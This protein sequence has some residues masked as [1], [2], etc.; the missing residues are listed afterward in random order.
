M[1]VTCKLWNTHLV[2]ISDC[3]K[4]NTT[5]AIKAHWKNFCFIQK[6]CSSCFHNFCYPL[7]KSCPYSHLQSNLTNFVNDEEKKKMEIYY[8]LNQLYL[9]KQQFYWTELWRFSLVA[10]TF[11]NS[12]ETIL[13]LQNFATPRK[14]YL[15]LIWNNEPEWLLFNSLALVRGRYTCMTNWEKGQ[16]GN[17]RWK[18]WVFT[19]QA[20]MKH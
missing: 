17:I 16:E 15:I 18:R 4:W 5:I 1:C 10:K 20:K 19:A 9:V 11:E 12:P 7:D 13:S 2:P 8:Y 14:Q 3:D 6:I